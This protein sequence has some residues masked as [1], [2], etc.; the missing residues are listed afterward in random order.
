[1]PSRPYYSGDFLKKFFLTNGSNST[2][3]SLKKVCFPNVFS[4]LRLLPNRMPN[5]SSTSLFPILAFNQSSWE[6]NFL[7]YFLNTY[8]IITSS[9]FRS[10]VIK[11]VLCLGIILIPIRANLLSVVNIC[12]IGTAVRV[13]QAS[14][15]DIRPAFSTLENVSMLAKVIV[16]IFL[17]SSVRRIL[18]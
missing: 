18:K 9:L 6:E 12:M 17:S 3:S 10:T 14:M 5:L 4:F 8:L 2:L 11:Q 1:M 15:L 13:A 7:V 16:Q